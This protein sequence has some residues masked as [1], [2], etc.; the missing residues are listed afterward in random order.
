MARYQHLP[1]Y[2]AALDLTVHVEQLVAGFSRYHKYPLGAELRA[3]S[4]GV[5]QQVLKANNAPGAAERKVELLVLR[6]RIDAPTS[7]LRFVHVDH[8]RCDD[9]PATPTASSSA[10]PRYPQTC[11]RLTPRWNHAPGSKLTPRWK[12]LTVANAV[13]KRYHPINLTTG[14]PAWDRPPPG[15]SA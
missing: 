6:E 8:H 14:Q 9:R 7:Y 15:D 3:G 1:I 2:Q 13:V 11:S 4:R 12:R 5:L 10:V